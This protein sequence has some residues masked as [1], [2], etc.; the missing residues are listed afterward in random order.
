[1]MDGYDLWLTDA[2]EPGPDPGDEIPLC[3]DCESADIHQSIN[4]GAVSVWCND[5][6]WHYPYATSRH[7][8]WFP[9]L[10]GEWECE[11]KEQEEDI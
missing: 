11:F 9:D 1:M 10:R 2:P 7:F 8:I 6:Q 3:R 5:C 4:N